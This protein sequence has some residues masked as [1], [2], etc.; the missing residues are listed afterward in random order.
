MKCL[1]HF[2]CFRLEYDLDNRVGNPWNYRVDNSA[3]SALWGNLSGRQNLAN[4]NVSDDKVI[5]AR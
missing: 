2:C 3:Q 4:L 5:E 1:Y